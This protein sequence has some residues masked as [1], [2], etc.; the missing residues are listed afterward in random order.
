MISWKRNLYI[1]WFTQILSIMSFGFGLPFMPFYI[2]ELGV[3]EPDKIKL[4]TG[5]LSMAP[6][7]TMA[8]MAPIWGMLSD[9]FGRKLMIMRAMIAASFIIGGMGLVGNVWHL[10]FLRLLQGI[11][12]GTITAATAFVAADAPSERMSYALGFMS[13][14]TFIGFSIGPVIGGYFAETMGYRF[15]FMVGGILMFVGFLLVL[16]LVKEDKKKVRINSEKQEKN[17]Y[18]KIFTPLV[19]GLLFIL[20][21]HRITRSV[22]S[23]YMPIFIQEMLNTTEGAAK[24]TGYANG[25]VGFAT[26]TAGL[27]ISR[28]GDRLNKINL[29]TV[30]LMIAVVIAYQLHNTTTLIQFILLYGLMFFFLGGVEPI[31][32]STTAQNTPEEYRGSLFGFQALVG[33]IGWMLSPVMGAWIS[34]QYGVKMILWV[35]PIAILINLILIRFVKFR[36]LA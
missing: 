34:V 32:I 8:I 19:I 10:V 33:S 12:T 31:I 30:L 13:S 6:A 14:S 16:A 35:I 28:L 11:F 36:K 2:Q 24:L 17:G 29:I 25:L 18:K 4:F 1:L 5:V 7:V 26:A 22:F 3:V 27:T 9:R 21:F 15:S 20:M 23:P